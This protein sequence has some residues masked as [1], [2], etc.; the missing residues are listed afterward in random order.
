[1]EI[2]VGTTSKRINDLS[3]PALS[4]KYTVSCEIREPC[5]LTAP[6]FILLRKGGTYET[7]NYVYVAKWSRYYFINDITV[8]GNLIELE[9]S[10]DYLGSWYNTIANQ[11]LYCLRCADSGYYNTKLSDT[12]YGIEDSTHTSELWFYPFFETLF[13]NGTFIISVNGP[14]GS[15]SSP[16]NIGA[17]AYY[18]VSRQGLFD[19]QSTL[20]AQDETLLK[21][22]QE[23]LSNPLQYINSC[24]YLPLNLNGL[25]PFN[26][27]IRAVT[28]INFT[29]GFSID[30]TGIEWVLNGS[31]NVSAPTKVSD[32]IT[33]EKSDLERLFNSDELD[34]Q[35]YAPFSTYT[36]VGYPIGTHQLSEDLITKMINIANGDDSGQ[37]DIKIDC[38]I[39]TGEAIVRLQD[40]NGYTYYSQNTQIGVNIPLAQVNQNWIGAALDAT[41]GIASLAVSLL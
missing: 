3:S 8:N 20:Y 4:V 11:N 23:W 14:S 18:L 33:L 27:Y 36:L 16:N 31:T 41:E 2:Q 24:M 12:Y 29:M 37:L 19:I 38:D 39:T 7:C 9:C 1:M 30:F 10:E 40:E 32:S 15:T 28:E 35:K 26:T 25:Y 34:Y 21:Q 22:I 5:S 17:P 6:T 13:S